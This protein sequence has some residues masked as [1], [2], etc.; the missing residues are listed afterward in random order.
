M[1]KT[2][3]PLVVILSL[4]F[5]AAAQSF[6][7]GSTGADGALDLAVMSCNPCEIQL[8]ESGILNY[9]TIRIPAGKVVRFKRNFRNTPVTLLAQG[10]VVVEGTVDLG[11]KNNSRNAGPGGYEGGAPYQPGFGAGGGSGDGSTGRWV[12]TLSLVPIAGG[13]GGGGYGSSCCTFNG[14][15]GGGAIVIASSTSLTVASGALISANGALGDGVS[16]GLSPGGSS[17]S[18]GAMRLVANVLTVNGRLEAVSAHVDQ[19]GVIRLEAPAGALTYNGTSKPLP[20]L[21]TTINPVV[22][23]DSS[24]PALN[25]A[26]VGGYPISYTAGRVDSVDLILPSAITDPISVG[27]QAKNVPVGTQVNLSVSGSSG[28]TFTPGTLSGTQAS[29]TATVAVSGLSRTNVSYL[30]A[31]V[32]FALPPNVAAF[33]PGGADHVATVRIDAAAGAKPKLIFLRKDGTVIPPAAVPGQLLRH[34]GL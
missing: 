21:S 25:I 10:D 3:S 20:I 27:V 17:G 24:T 18:G 31:T 33:N 34:L 2:L 28:M 13:S 30:I 26:S 12:G 16:G 7:S 22:V 23:P 5:F 11:A 9:T 32:E 8:P 14:G 1:R 15:G 19:P 4:P 6:S 29:S